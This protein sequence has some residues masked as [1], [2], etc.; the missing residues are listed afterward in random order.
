MITSHKWPPLNCLRGFEA[1]ARLNS[2]SKAASELNM[3]QSAVSHQIKTL[4]NYLEQPLFIRVNRKVILADAGIDLLETTE[5]CLNILEDGLKRLEQYKKPNQLIVHTPSAFASQWLVPR[6]NHFREQHNDTDIWLYTTDGEPDLDLAE[7]H[8]AILYGRGRWPGMSSTK[9]LPDTLVPLCSP[10]FPLMEL[11][12]I[13]AEDFVDYTLLHGEQRET[14]QTWFASVGLPETNPITGPNFTNPSLMLQAAKQGQGIALGSLIL[15]ADDIE[16]G[17]LV[18]PVNRGVKSRYAY[19]MVHK[20]EGLD[21]PQLG[22]FINWLTKQTKEFHD[23]I[24][25]QLKSGLI[26]H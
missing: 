5:E 22:L 14:W 9:L 19:Y 26:E 10:D 21:S 18:C 23:T 16:K 3:T 1:A 13:S 7:V 2:F 17:A 24:Y 8:V 12:D 25:L 15:A 20:H 4:E 6:L 11:H